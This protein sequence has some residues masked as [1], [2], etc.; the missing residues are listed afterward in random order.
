MKKPMH[1]TVTTLPDAHALFLDF[2]ASGLHPDSYPIEVAIFGAAGSPYQRLIKPVAYWAHWS[3]D[4]QD[5]H[6][7][8]REQLLQAGTEVSVVAQELNQ[9][10][11]NKRL[12]VDNNHDTF[13]MD[14]LFEAAGCEPLFE[15]MNLMHVLS[16]DQQLAFRRHLPVK[17]VHR[18]LPD[19]MNLSQA[20]VNYLKNISC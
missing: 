12:W 6:Q 14:V 5:L 9:Q 7:I 19:A 1:T 13:W 4:A 18:A 15:V 16:E 17:T 10:F 3:Y 11:A 2:E 8:E 20:W